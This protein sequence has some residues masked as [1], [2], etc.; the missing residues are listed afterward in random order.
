VD[1]EREDRSQRGKHYILYNM[2]FEFKRCNDSSMIKTYL[3][4]LGSRGTCVEGGREGGYGVSK[5]EIPH[6]VGE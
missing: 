1:K 2:S 4:W 3:Y 6:K 5:F